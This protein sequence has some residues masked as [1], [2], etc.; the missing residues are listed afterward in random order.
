MH[1]IDNCSDNFLTLSSYVKFCFIS[2][3]CV[4]IGAYIGIL[5]NYI[6]IYICIA[7]VYLFYFRSMCPYLTT[8]NSDI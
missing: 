5:N 6:C 8:V 1:C 7:L 4:H 3:V 2:G